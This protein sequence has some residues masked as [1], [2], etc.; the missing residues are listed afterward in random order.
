VNDVEIAGAANLQRDIVRWRPDAHLLMVRNEAKHEGDEFLEIECD[1]C[2]KVV[3]EL[4]HAGDLAL[5]VDC[6]DCNAGGVVT[7]EC[8]GCG[9]ASAEPLAPCRA[10][11]RGC[12]S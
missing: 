10:C 4:H 3:S 8:D 5:C 6:W 12:G 11:G 9:D 7:V 1:G 2:G